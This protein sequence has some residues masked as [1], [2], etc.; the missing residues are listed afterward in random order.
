MAVFSWRPTNVQIIASRA[1]PGPGSTVAPL[2]PPNTLGSMGTT[3]VQGWKTQFITIPV[4]NIKLNKLSE[5][6]IYENLV[7][8]DNSLT[9]TE[10]F[11]ENKMFVP[12][13]RK[14][15]STDCVL[16][17]NIIRK[18]QETTAGLPVGGNADGL[19][20]A[21]SGLVP[22]GFDINSSIKINERQVRMYFTDAQT[23][24][25][26][27]SL[28]MLNGMQYNP[29]SNNTESAKFLNL[30]SLIRY[31]NKGTAGKELWVSQTALCS[32]TTP[33]GLNSTPVST[34]TSLYTPLSTAESE[35]GIYNIT[36]QNIDNI[37]G[38][39]QLSH[40]FDIYGKNNSAV[41]EMST[42]IGRL[43]TFA[44]AYSVATN[45]GDRN[46]AKSALK[47]QFVPAVTAAAGALGLAPFPAATNYIPDNHASDDAAATDIPLQ[48]F[49][50]F[51]QTYNGVN[52]NGNGYAGDYWNG[53]A[54]G[55]PHLTELALAIYKYICS[56]SATVLVY[57]TN[58]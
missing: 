33:P 49:G 5:L 45:D 34:I 29:D 27:S 4:I 7:S 8:L 15:F 31:V 52:G 36:L 41:N 22:M 24:T 11:L 18:Y 32:I 55:T 37:V 43:K 20:F 17:F 53:D 2:V 56:K 9:Q 28:N 6:Q 54:A 13:Q 48:V 19:S 26:P 46:N 44:T 58:N 16:M 39:Q 30:K 40:L 21:F 38:P 10:W 50:H 25:T 35:F 51:I 42:F 23:P 47:L 1:G 57:S 3:M 14:F 12:K